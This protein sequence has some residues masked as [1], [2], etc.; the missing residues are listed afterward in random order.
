MLQS[1][2]Q[3]GKLDRR[4]TF[5]KKVIE[6]GDSNEDKIV[7]W[8]EVAINPT[9]SAS[10]NDLQ[11]YEAMIADRLTYVQPTDWMIRFEDG[12]N[13]TTEMRLV[14]ETRVYAILA[15]TEPRGQRKRFLEV[16]TKLLDNEYFT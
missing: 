3:I 5:I 9:V 16:K 14:Y 11:G 2:Q 8:E 1:H 7:G 15:I 10:K 12:R 4:I 13:K 6:D